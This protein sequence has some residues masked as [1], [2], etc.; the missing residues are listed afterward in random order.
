MALETTRRRGFKVLT[1][2]MFYKPCF[3]DLNMLN[4]EKILK[5]KCISYKLIKLREKSISAKDVV[6]HGDV[7]AEE[8]CKTIIIKDKKRNFYACF[9]KGGDTVDKDKLRNILSS[10][11]S[12]AT[13]EN[14]KEIAKVNPGEVCPILL[15]IKI[16]V[17]QK[18]TELKKVNFGS[19]DLYYG[20]EMKIEDLLKI[21]D[22]YEVKD[23]IL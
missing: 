3:Y 14:V 20:I 4:V 18:V 15:N 2:I 11:T 16:F 22:D 13:H 12:I 9:L 17:D 1:R 5:E 8:I 7:N 23:L 6:K 21:L 19:G 10:K